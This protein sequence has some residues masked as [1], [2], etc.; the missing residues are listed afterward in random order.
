MEEE[1]KQSIIEEGKKNSVLEGGQEEE[2]KILVVENPEQNDQPV[3]T[4]KI[5]DPAQNEEGPIQDA[6]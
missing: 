5:Q 3:E 4:E 2:E 6:P 1:K